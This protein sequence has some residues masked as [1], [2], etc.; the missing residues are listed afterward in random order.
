M[1]TVRIDGVESQTDFSSAQSVNEL[2]ELV[3]SVIDPQSIIVSIMHDEKELTEED[4]LSSQCLK[5]SGVF[6]IS[7]GT[8]DDY[9]SERFYQAPV[10]LDHI[11]QQFLFVRECFQKSDKEEGNKVLSIAVEDLKAFVEWYNSLLFASERVDDVVRSKFVQR[12]ESLTSICE[13]LLQQHLYQSW[14]ALGETI[15]GKL[16]PVLSEILEDVTTLGSELGT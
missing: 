11:L 9:L 5:G 15:E 14:W 4:W 7:T 1:V 13:Q 3:Q 6:D 2:V 12:I 16:A 8:R 10:L